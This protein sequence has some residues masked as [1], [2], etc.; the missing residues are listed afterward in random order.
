MIYQKQTYNELKIGIIEDLALISNWFKANKLALN[1]SKTKYII[2]HKR[3][4]K[5]PDNFQIMINGVELERVNNTKFLGVLIQENLMWDTHINYICNRVS[6]ATALLAKL[7]HY[8]P[9]YVLMLIYNSLCLSHMT[10]ALS[11]WGAAPMSAIGR[12][13]K[14]HKKGIRHVSNSKY[15]AHTEPIF[16]REKILKFEDLFKL[17]CIK[18][19]HKKVHNTLH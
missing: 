14:L 9:K 18:L 6:K 10:Y 12:L 8:L 17:Q 19:V 3:S 13:H 11:V 7:K 2:F 5:P 16:K 4:N 15:N 1:E